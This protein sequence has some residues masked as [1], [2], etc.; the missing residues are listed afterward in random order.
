MD[1]DKEMRKLD[2]F[3]KWF[4]ILYLSGF[5]IAIAWVVIDHVRT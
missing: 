1:Y 3:V 5:I 4:A 2:R